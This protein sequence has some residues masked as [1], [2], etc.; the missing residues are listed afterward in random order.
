MGKK[1]TIL[2]IFLLVMLPIGFLA[3]D[4]ILTAQSVS[5]EDG[6]VIGSVTADVSNDLSQMEIHIPIETKSGGFL[7]KKVAVD[8]EMVGQGTPIEFAFEF[9]LGTET[10]ISK[11]VTLPTGD[12]AWLQGNS[13]TLTYR[14]TWAKAQIKIYGIVLPI[15]QEIDVES[16]TVTAP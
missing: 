16:F 2:I 10:V 1:L 15:E 11:A 14:V 7:P 8:M 13:T 12:T 5:A 3:V 6:V 9:A 4:L